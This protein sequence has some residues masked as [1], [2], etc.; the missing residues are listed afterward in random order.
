MGEQYSLS[1]KNSALSSLKETFKT[2][3]IG[4]ELGAGICE[5]K[6]NQVLSVTR[7]TWHNPEPLA[8]LYSLYKFAEASDHY[9][10]FTLTDLMDDSPERPGI[11]PAQI[12]GLSRE[13]LQQL[14]YQLSLNY[15]EFISVVFNKDLESIYLNNE[16]TSLDVTELF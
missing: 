7:T 6:G 9:Y 10:S 14:M 2:S 11:S 5:M 15:G 8:I 12:F 1:V 4:N 3:P 16:K 13:T